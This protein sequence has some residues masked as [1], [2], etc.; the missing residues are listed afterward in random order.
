MATVDKNF[1]VKNGL[2]VEGTTATVNGDNIVTESA[3]QTLSNK[4]FTGE[5]KFHAA[6]GAGRLSVNLDNTTG[7]TTLTGNNGDLNLVANSGDIVLNASGTIHAQSPLHA[8]SGISTSGYVFGPATANGAGLT[9]TT[10]QDVSAVSITN[11]GD[12]ILYPYVGKAYVGGT[13]ADKEITTKGYVDGLA[14]NYDAA[15]AAAQALTDANSYTDGKVSALVDSAPDLLNTL[16]ELAAAIADNPNYASDV[17]NLVAGKADTSYVETQLSAVD[18]AA[19]GYASSAQLAAQG[20]ADGLA[21]NYDAAGAAASAETAAKNYADG[22]ATNYDPAG[23]AATAEYNAKGYADGLAANYDPAGSALAAEGNAKAY[24]DTL[25]SNYDAA[26]AAASAASIAE[27]NANGYTD[28]AIASGNVT[29]TPSYAGIHLGYYATEVAGYASGNTGATLVPYTF[30]SGVKSGKFVV[31][32]MSNS[33]G[34][35]QMSEILVTADSSNNVAITEYAIVSTNG[36]MGDITADVT[37]GGNIEIIV[38]P[39]H[40]SS[41]VMISGTV[42][43]WND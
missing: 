36:N 28:S 20:Y 24:A 30:P 8:D 4:E 21:I 2:V 40:D 3:S 1:K 11:D 5:I 18:T 10:Y 6:N 37:G 43:N 17:A 31:R 16:N 9:L 32:I 26:G 19:Q 35:S 7:E 34:D 38:S 42:F 41:E 12:V 25:A 14:S 27:S 22:L 33:T 23:S 29:A 39:T 15:G 13:S